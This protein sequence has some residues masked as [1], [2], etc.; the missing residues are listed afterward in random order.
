MPPAGKIWIGYGRD[1]RRTELDLWEPGSRLLL[2][3][4][5]SV[6]LSALTAVSSKESGQMPI[7]LDLDGSLANHLSG[8]LDTYD[9]RSLLYDSFRLSDPEAWHSQLAAAAYSVAMD[10]SSEEE[11]IINSAMQAVASEGTL[12]SPV[13]LH[14]VMGKVE[15]FRG[16][17]VDKLDGRIASLKLFD[18]VD[19]E[20]FDRVAKGNIV[21]DFHSAPYPQAAELSLALF[22]AKILTVSHSN[23]EERR[24]ILL[25]EAHR[26]FK[27]SP[28]VQHSNRLLIHLMAT[29]SVTAISTSQQFLLDPLI[30]RSFHIGIYSRDAWLQHPPTADGIP[31][32]PC[33]LVDRRR[34][35]SLSFVPRRIP[36]KTSE[37]IPAKPSKS[38]TEELVRT[39]LEEVARYPLSTRDS[40]A[41]YLVPQFLH[42]DTNSAIS[43]LESEGCLA[44]EPKDSGAGPRVFAYSLSETGRKRL[45]ELKG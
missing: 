17:Y 34:D 15:G 2:L 37:Y 44:L 40:L 32:G 20:T 38:P 25:N 10:L 29:N 6:A 36:S 35:T 27:S 39:I 22:L 4:S 3:G 7:I 41:D 16:F 9:Y 21:I 28:R 33:I 45:E 1:G 43:F 11:A 5:K 12:L 42:S 24:L 18:A 30:L 8:H 14:D 19:D 23:P 13:S 26:V 31:P